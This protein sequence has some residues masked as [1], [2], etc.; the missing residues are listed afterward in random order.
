VHQVNDAMLATISA[1]GQPVNGEL[2]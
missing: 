1:S 2:K